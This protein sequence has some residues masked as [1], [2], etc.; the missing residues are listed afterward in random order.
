VSDGREVKFSGEVSEKD[1]SRAYFFLVWRDSSLWLYIGIVSL[2]LLSP[3]ATDYRIDV[4]L[5]TVV[6]VVFIY[7]LISFFIVGPIKQRRTYKTYDKSRSKFLWSFSR[8]GLSISS[9]NSY[10]TF[11]FS[12]IRKVFNRKDYLYIQMKISRKSVKVIPKRYLSDQQLG[13]IFELIPVNEVKI[14]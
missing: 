14:G 5:Q 1:Y 13:D 6:Y 9:D 4:A 7:I 10:K 3:L 11:T 12:E 2:F 8:D